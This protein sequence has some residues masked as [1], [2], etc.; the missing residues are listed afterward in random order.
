MT[1]TLA[2]PPAEPILY[3]PNV[4]A[5]L[6]DPEGR[7]LVAERISVDG[8]WQ[9]PQGGVDDSESFDDALFREL[10]EEIGVHASLITILT[11][12]GGYRYDFPK[13]RLKYGI[14]GGQEQTYYLCDFHGTDDDIV[15]DT[16]HREFARYRWIKPEDFKLSWV[17]RFKRTT[18]IAVFKDFFGIDL[19]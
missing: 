11:K 18:Y 15:L 17:P 12:K 19:Q 7:I 2:I 8:A 1:P 6:R 5:I 4:A 3:R 16:H 13:G 9:F 14:Y 10:E